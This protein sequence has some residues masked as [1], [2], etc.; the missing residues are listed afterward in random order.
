MK[1]NITYEMDIA[2]RA[3]MRA[4]EAVEVRQSQL[5]KIVTP[6]IDSEL[7]WIDQ[8]VRFK[9]G[10]KKTEARVTGYTYELNSFLEVFEGL[11]VTGVEVHDKNGVRVVSLDK[12]LWDQPEKP[13]FDDVEDEHRELPLDEEE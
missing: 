11:K 2:A 4:T 8:E 7:G 10:R 12:L 13:D 5:D 1:L 9:D 3:L 6:A